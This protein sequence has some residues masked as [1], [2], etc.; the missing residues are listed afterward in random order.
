MNGEDVSARCFYADDRNGVVRLYK[1]N[2]NG[3][4]YVRGTKGDPE[5][6]P[7]W[8]EHRM[9]CHDES[10]NLVE[11]KPFHGFGEAATEERRGR[12]RIELAR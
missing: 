12:V 3:H 11:L 10:G 1:L 8:P 2:A 7:E 5:W 9:Y 6:R 4:K